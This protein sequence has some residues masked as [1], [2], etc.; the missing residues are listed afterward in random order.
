MGE[1]EV[2]DRFFDSRSPF[3]ILF[4]EDEETS[5]PMLVIFTFKKIVNVREREIAPVKTDRLAQKWDC[6]P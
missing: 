3:L 6:Q 1:V 5:Q 2:E 4:D